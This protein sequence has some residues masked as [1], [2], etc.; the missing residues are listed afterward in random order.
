M[1]GSRAVGLNIITSSDIVLDRLIVGGIER[2]SELSAQNAAD[3]EA[4]YSICAY[5]GNNDRC[6][7]VSLTNSI[8]TGCYY[9][10]FVAPGHDCGSAENQTNF[11]GNLA[12]S[13]FGSGAYIYPDPNK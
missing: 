1:I 10:G 7:N 5:I 4:C 11:R 13:V 6:S 12:H 9:A 3:I 8:A 2:R